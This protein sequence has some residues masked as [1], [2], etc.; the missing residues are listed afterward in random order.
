M[1]A[2]SQLWLLCALRAIIFAL[3]HVSMVLSMHRHRPFAVLSVLCKVECSPFSREVEAT[4]SE[5]LNALARIL[6]IYVAD[7][8]GGFKS[9]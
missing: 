6:V 3:R 5:L 8:L 4:G 1:Y 9:A 7:W 2:H